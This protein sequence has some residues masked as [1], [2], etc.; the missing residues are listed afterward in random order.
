MNETV[1]KDVFFPNYRNDRP[2]RT[3]RSEPKTQTHTKKENFLFLLFFLVESPK[4]NRASVRNNRIDVQFVSGDAKRRSRSTVETSTC[5]KRSFFLP[6]TASS[7]C[8]FTLLLRLSLAFLR[9]LT[10]DP[11][12][13][14]LLS[15]RPIPGGGGG[16]GGGPPPP[17]PRASDGGM[18]G[19]TPISGGRGMPLPAGRGMAGAGGGA[20]T[21]AAAIIIIGGAGGGGGGGGGAP[22]PPPTA[23]G[24]SGGA[25][26]AELVR[27]WPAPELL[28]GATPPI[29]CSAGL[30]V[31]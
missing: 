31:E 25:I 26:G 28:A 19:A 1:N 6:I 11:G 22:P 21:A 2:L 30:L 10:S 13:P 8:R 17:P 5:S 3:A 16:G 9:A 15:D 20:G 4:K 7:R 18:G 12:S 14:S 27:W 23:V 24:G 29:G